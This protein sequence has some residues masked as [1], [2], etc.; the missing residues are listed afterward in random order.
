MVVKQQWHCWY[1][2]PFERKVKC[3]ICQLMFISKA[4]RCFSHLGYNTMKNL[5]IVHCKVPNMHVLSMFWGSYDKNIPQ[6]PTPQVPMPPGCS[7]TT[8]R[9]VPLTPTPSSPLTN[10]MLI[11]KMKSSL[12]GLASIPRGCRNV[13]RGVGYHSRA[14]F[15][16]CLQCGNVHLLMTHGHHSPMNKVF[17]LWQHD[18]RPSSKPWV[19]PLV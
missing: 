11:L 16:P 14:Q 19:Q 17:P 13:V 10:Y 1:N 18:Q 4:D 12:L 15:K 9:S 2:K 5:C 6:W 3:R 7:A 8:G